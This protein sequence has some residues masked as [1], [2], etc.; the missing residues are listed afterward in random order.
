MTR[1]R[2]I[3][4]AFAAVAVV[5]AFA[6]GDDSSPSVTPAPSTDIPTPAPSPTPLDRIV[7]EADLP[8]IMLESGGASQD[9]VP[10]A[11]EWVGLDCSIGGWSYDYY[12]I[13]GEPLHLATG[14]GLSLVT[15]VEPERLIA[16]TW[17]PDLA[18]ST[19][20]DSGELA[21]PMD[22]TNLARRGS[23]EELPVQP[24]DGQQFDVAELAPGQYAVEILG[25][26]AD[27]T[28]TLAFHIVIEQ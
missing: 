18:N 20:I 10:L 19:I 17:E 1:V 14:D 6:C 21:L 7:C 22:P 26:W 12:Y 27:G 3:I 2:L 28:A 24:S 11:L 25:F 13:P 8:E 4:T 15:S 23:A 9:A 16:W 5:T